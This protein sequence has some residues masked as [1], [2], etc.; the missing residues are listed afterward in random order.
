MHLG[1]TLNETLSWG[2]H[3]NE[4]IKRTAVTGPIGLLKHMNHF[5][6][7]NSKLRVYTSFIWPQ[8]EYGSQVFDSQLTCN[9]QDHLE[10]IQRKALLACTAAYACTSYDKLLKD[11]GL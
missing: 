6:D 8:L 9:Q 11:V 10:R 2:N 5:I 1:I 4:P 3:I 7:R